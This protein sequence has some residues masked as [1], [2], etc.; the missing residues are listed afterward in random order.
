MP[1]HLNREAEP[2]FVQSLTQDI[3]SH[4][5]NLS[6]ALSPGELG[7]RRPQGLQDPGLLPT[8]SLDGSIQMLTGPI[9]APVHVPEQQLQSQGHL[10]PHTRPALARGPRGAYPRGG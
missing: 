1:R 2:T 10:G 9:R 7:D 8:F 3:T 5:S 6:L 4:A